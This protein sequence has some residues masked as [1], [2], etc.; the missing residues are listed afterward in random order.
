VRVGRR[1]R[2]DRV[3]SVRRG[4]LATETRV[5][6]P[7]AVLDVRGTAELLEEVLDPPLP[8]PLQGLL[9]ER[10]SP[11]CARSGR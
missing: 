4:R 9:A 3:T 10:G 1:E 8:D 11:R 6:L 5:D 2:G 7:A